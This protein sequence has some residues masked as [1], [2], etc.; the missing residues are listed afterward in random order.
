MHKDVYL[1]QVLHTD[2]QWCC[3]GHS[4]LDLTLHAGVPVLWLTAWRYVWR[5][6]TQHTPFPHSLSPAS[7]SRSPS[8]R[9]SVSPF[10]SRSRHSTVL[11]AYL[12]IYPPRWLFSVSVSFSEL[13]STLFSPFSVTHSL[14]FFQLNLF[15]PATFNQ[16]YLTLRLNLG[17]VLCVVSVCAPDSATTC[18][19]LAEVVA[20]TLHEQTRLQISG[21]IRSVPSMTLAG[22][23]LWVCGFYVYV[24]AEREGM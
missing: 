9:L 17:W 18:M 15:K 1:V 10:V 7:I 11:F 16:R 21:S 23:T 4:L 13:F 8:L 22:M 19:F 6:Q 3:Q 14:L 12:C 2:T 5:I 20:H 24:V